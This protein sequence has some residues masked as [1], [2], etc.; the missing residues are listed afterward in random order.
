MHVWMAST[1]IFQ[2]ERHPKC[3]HEEYGTQVAQIDE[4]PFGTIKAWMGTTHFL[5]KR[6]KNVSTEMDFHVLAYNLKRMMTIFGEVELTG[7]IAKA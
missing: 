2:I 3:H 1:P 5:T 4:H 6:L 7:A